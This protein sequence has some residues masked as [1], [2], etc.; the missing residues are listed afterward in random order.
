ML[1]IIIYVTLNIDRTLELI[2][3]TQLL[4]EFYH[5]HFFLNL[6][7]KNFEHTNKIMLLLLKVKTPILF[8]KDKCEL[9]ITCNHRY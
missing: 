1:Y 4:L 9:I 2:V 8:C 3:F 5:I 7:P 6:K